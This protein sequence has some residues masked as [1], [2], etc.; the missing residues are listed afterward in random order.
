MK[1]PAYYWL[2]TLTIT[3]SMHADCINYKKKK[4][5]IDDKW[6]ESDDSCKTINQVQTASNLMWRI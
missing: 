2:F 1:K 3:P 5:M 6:R 4:K